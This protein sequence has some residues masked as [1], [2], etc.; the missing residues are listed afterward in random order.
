MV[1]FLAHLTATWS[2]MYSNSAPLRTVIEFAHVGGLIAGGG[3]AIAADRLTIQ[4]AR[5]DADD[6]QRQIHHIE[7]VHFVVLAGLVFVVAS[8][9]LLF[10]ADMDTYLH[11]KVFWVKMACVVAL[12]VNGA[13]LVVAGRRAEVGSV[14][15]WNELKRAAVASLALWFVTTLLGVALPN[16]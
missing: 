13:R 6:R 3:T 15:G 4:A 8:G 12:V 1:T 11:S 5:R 7:N 2:S 9:L 10:L 14:D 16:V